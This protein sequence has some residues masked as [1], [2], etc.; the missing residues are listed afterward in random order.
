MNK[1]QEIA[2]KIL[3]KAM[4]GVTKYTEY[5][6]LNDLDDCNR[7]DVHDLLDGYGE[8]KTYILNGK[9]ESFKINDKGENFVKSGGYRGEFERRKEEKELKDLKKKSMEIGIITSMET[10]EIAKRAE[11]R[12]KTANYIAM[13]SILISVILFFL[14]QIIAAT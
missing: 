2:D 7:F 11:K 6:E 12:A 1:N 3:R 10:V 9:W 5:P 13:A 4:M 8:F 14:S